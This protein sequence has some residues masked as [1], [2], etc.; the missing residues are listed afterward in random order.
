VVALRNP[1][2]SVSVC[3]KPKVPNPLT[4]QRI[5]L[6]GEA[7]V[8]SVSSNKNIGFIFICLIP[9]VERLL[10]IINSSGFYR[11]EEASISQV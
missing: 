11:G 9:E 3:I 4:D 8:F 2:L 7:V 6:A 5:S 10:I 1:T